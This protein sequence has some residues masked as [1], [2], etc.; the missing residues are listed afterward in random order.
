MNYL[1][2]YFVTGATGF[3]GSHLIRELSKGHNRIWCLSR[4]PLRAQSVGALVNWIEADL[5]DT[6]RY[7]PVLKNTEYVVHLAGAL[8]ARSEEEF[9]RTN[10]RAT[11][12]LL[13][14]C[15]E[16]RAPIKQFLHMSSIAA[17][18]PNYVGDLLKETS[19][20]RPETVYGKTKYHGELAVS[21][22]AHWFPVVILR[23]AFVYGE[24]DARVAKFL[25]SV[26]AGSPSLLRLFV[27]TISV[28]HVSDVVRSCLHSLERTLDSGEVFITSDPVPYSWDQILDLIREAVIDIL[29][30]PQAEETAMR[31]MLQSFER[32]GGSPLRFARQQYWGCNTEKAERLLGFR[33][34]VSLSDGV[35]EAV[36]WCHAAGYLDHILKSVTS[37]SYGVESYEK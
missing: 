34:L 15:R 16:V 2:N 9:Y 32:P 21:N 36:R 24:G 19:P 5:D 8:T 23:P 20:C 17:M 25:Q 33:T 10:V 6:D 27:K 14:L 13:N 35:R 1:A 12:T 3:I 31:K 37:Y 4:K 22:A 7:R 18:G 29:G 11:Q 28:C 30:S 26:L